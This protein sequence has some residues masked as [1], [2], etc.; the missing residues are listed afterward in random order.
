MGKKIVAII[1]SYR[2]DGVIDSAVEAILSAAREKGAR[3]NTLRL[4][5]QHIE[6]CTNCRKC[7]QLQGPDRGICVQKDDLQSVLEAIDSADA[8]VLASPVNFGNVTAISRR[9]MERLIGYA[10]W[11]WGQA[12]PSNRKMPRTSSAV[13]VSSSAMPALMMLLFTGA[14]KALKQMAAVLGSK[15]VGTLWIGLA[16]RDAHYRLSPREMTRA[17]KLGFRLAS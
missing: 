3:T 4:T 13:L 16:A 10:Y 17:R 14:A 15:V 11:P 5:E 7:T 8:I 6:F 12:A 9:F 2:I 1:G